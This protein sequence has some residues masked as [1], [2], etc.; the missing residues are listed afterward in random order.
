MLGF[1][2]DRY[3]GTVA[4]GCPGSVFVSLTNLLERTFNNKYVFRLYVLFSPAI[5]HEAMVKEKRTNK[6][7]F[8]LLQNLFFI[9]K[10]R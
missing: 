10:I 1:P 3:R 4:P 5:G 6:M 8:I 7:T 9:Y 2:K